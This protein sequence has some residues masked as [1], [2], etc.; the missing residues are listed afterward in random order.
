MRVKQNSTGK[1]LRLYFLAVVLC[2]LIAAVLAPDRGAMLTG[3]RDILLSPAQLTRDYFFLG[4]ISGTFLNM[5][6]VGA[7]CTALTCLPGAVLKGSTVAAFFLT[8]GFSAW[9]IN[10]LNLWP[11]LIGVALHALARRK[12]LAEFVDLFLFSTALCPLVSDLLLRYPGGEVHAITAAGALLALAVG[13]AVGFLTPAIAGHS[14]NLHKGYNLYSAALPGG[15]LGL[16]LVALLYKTAGYEVP[17][18]EATLG[19]SHPEVVIPFCGLVFLATAAL[20]F[21]L[22]GRSFRG[23]LGLLRSSGHKEDFT[24]KHGLGLAILNLGIYGLFILAYY[25]LVGA[26]FNSVTMGIM[27]CMVCFGAAGSHPGNVW[28]ILLGYFLA[29]LLGVN[30]INAQAILVGACFA[31]GLAPLTGAYGWW[32]GLI[33]GAAHYTL[34]TSIPALHGGFCLYNGG[35]TS[36]LITVILVP[37]L[38]MF[39]KTKEERRLARASRK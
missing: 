4:N 10:I 22:N 11:F 32:A 8:L 39:C 31:S 1:T 27:F 9:G 20:G 29:S 5:A 23:Y 28:P 25:C 34:V 16:F 18:I 26:S 13:V 12:P 15:L 7:V 24:A 6:L 37:Q 2:C 35:F 19:D 33:G 14:P 3:L 38:E 17:P 30:A 21:V 36:L